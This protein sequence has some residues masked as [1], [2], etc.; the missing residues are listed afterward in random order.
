MD[1]EA[2]FFP[3]MYVFFVKELL[4]SPNS[5]PS[6]LLLGL[7]HRSRRGRGHRLSDHQRNPHKYCNQSFGPS[8]YR[9]GLSVYFSDCGLLEDCQTSDSSAVSLPLQATN[10]APTDLN[11]KSDPYLLVRIGQ[12]IL[13]TKDRYIPKQLNPSFGESVLLSPSTFLNAL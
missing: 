7:S 11:G 9:Q 2:F 8:V 3:S 4:V 12:Q 10:L 1:G 5:L 13:D 6:G